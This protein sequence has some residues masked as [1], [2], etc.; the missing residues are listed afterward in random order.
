MAL[1]L[2]GSVADFPESIEEDGT[3]QRILLL[4]LIGVRGL[5]EENTR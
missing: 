1:L 4:A 2:I 3:A 5:S